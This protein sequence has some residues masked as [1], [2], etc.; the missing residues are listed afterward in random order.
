LVRFHG[1]RNV[2]LVLNRCRIDA[3]Y[4]YPEGEFRPVKVTYTWEEAGHEKRDE[5]IARSPSETYKI[6]CATKPT[7]KSLTLELA[8]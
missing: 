7:M 1:N 8:E 2:D 3:D 5:H 6:T 4:A